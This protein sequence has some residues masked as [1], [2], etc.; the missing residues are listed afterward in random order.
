[1]YHVIAKDTIMNEIAP[2]LPT[3]KRGFRPGA[4]QD[5]VG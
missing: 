5:Q 1:M 2:N 3:G 4:P